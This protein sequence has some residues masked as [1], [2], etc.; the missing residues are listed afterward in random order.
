MTILQ[1]N[2]KYIQLISL[3]LNAIIIGI[4][5]SNE[6]KSSNP[7]LTTIIVTILIFLI[8]N[9]LIIMLKKLGFNE[10][11]WSFTII[12]VAISISVYNIPSFI[13]YTRK[14]YTY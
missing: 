4:E 8:L 6:M 11:Y 2:L 9:Y 10:E 13:S 14:G 7:Y 1:N 12:T 3:W 5:V